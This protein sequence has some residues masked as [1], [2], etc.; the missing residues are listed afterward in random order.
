[1]HFVTEALALTYF[2]DHIGFGFYRCSEVAMVVL[3]K[4]RMLV[5]VMAGILALPHVAAAGSNPLG[6]EL[7]K[8]IHEED[9]LELSSVV[10]FD[11]LDRTIRGSSKGLSEIST[12]LRDKNGM[13]TSPG[14]SG[15]IVKDLTL[16]WYHIGTNLASVYDVDGKLANEDETKSVDEFIKKYRK[17]KKDENE[18][19]DWRSALGEIQ[20]ALDNIDAIMGVEGDLKLDLSFLSE[21]SKHALTLVS[22]QHDRIETLLGRYFVVRELFPTH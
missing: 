1:M 20:Q 3:S 9:T 7:P 21:D 2:K 14:T 5:L 10:I 13:F 18:G 16:I 11:K 4:P 6:G 22:W 19:N 8:E 12:Y 17:I 15:D